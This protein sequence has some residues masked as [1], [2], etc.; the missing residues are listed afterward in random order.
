MT[1]NCT[2][3]GT[4][5]LLVAL[6]AAMPAAASAQQPMND[7]SEGAPCGAQL[8]GFVLSGHD[9]HITSSVRVADVPTGTLQPNAVM[10]PVEVPI[11]GY[12]RARGVIDPRKGIDGVDFGLRF[13]LAL[14]DD[15][16]GRFLF[17]GGGG[18]NGALDPALGAMAAGKTPAIARG[19]AVVSTDSGHASGFVFDQAFMKDQRAALDFAL[20]SVPTVTL[21]AKALIAA[22][23]GKPAHHSYVT[24]CSTGGREGMLASQRYPELFDGVVAGAPAMRPLFARLGVRYGEVAFNQ[25]AQ[26]DAEGRPIV[27]KI[28]STGDRELIARGLLEQCDALD[29][30]ADGVIHNMRACRFDPSK[31]Q[32]GAGRTSGCLSAAQAKAMKDAFAGPRDRSGELVYPGFPYDTGITETGLF[33]PGFLPTGQPSMF[34]PPNRDLAFDI[35]QAAWAV[36][37]DAVEM[38][39][40]TDLWTNLSTFLGRGGKIIFYHGV[41]DP[42]FSAWDTLDYWERAARDNAARWPT[43]SRLYMVPGMG[44]CGGGS[45]AFQRFDLLDAIVHWVEKDEAPEAVVSERLMPSPARRPMCPWPS[46]PR[47]GNGDVTRPESFS[48]ARE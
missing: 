19:F 43:S 25:A 28:F 3:A 33:V 48:C 46:F 9:L 8:Q 29:G 22:Y 34:G 1:C 15:W 41:S 45:N 47:Y 37:R 30:L 18:F 32:C 4:G 39:T 26:R 13:E 6:A 38:L 2:R 10:P 12:C 21:A 24:G 35:D 31:L 16:N 17:Q 5:V 7:R 14:P 20:H 27:E 44:H 23:Y 36:R 40:N 42:W 11:P